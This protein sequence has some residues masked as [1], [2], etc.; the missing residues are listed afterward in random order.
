MRQ[1]RFEWDALS[2]SI[3]MDLTCFV[4]GPILPHLRLSRVYRFCMKKVLVA[5]WSSDTDW[6]LTDLCLQHCR[7]TPMTWPMTTCES[8]IKTHSFIQWG[9]CV[10]RGNFTLLTSCI[11]TPRNKKNM[12][13]LLKHR[14]NINML[15]CD[16]NMLMFSLMNVYHLNF[17]MLDFEG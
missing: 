2:N 13:I 10:Y 9:W 3:T 14:C 5:L 6:T 1:W 7:Q 12:W 11:R 15:T 16:N 17:H 4:A 8:L